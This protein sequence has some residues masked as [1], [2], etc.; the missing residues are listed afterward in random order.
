MGVL[1]FATQTAE[2]KQESANDNPGSGSDWADVT[3]V[4][5]LVPSNHEGRGGRIATAM[6]KRSLSWLPT[7]D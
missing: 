3:H 2:H 1:E 5:A 6:V 4:E 7:F